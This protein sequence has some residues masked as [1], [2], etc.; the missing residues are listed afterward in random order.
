MRYR[1]AAAILSYLVA[2]GLVAAGCGGHAT[3]EISTTTTSL[4]E[5]LQLRIL[6][7][8]VVPPVVNECRQALYKFP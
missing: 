3:K 1:G 5:G 2:A 6:A 4:A 8:A 7:P